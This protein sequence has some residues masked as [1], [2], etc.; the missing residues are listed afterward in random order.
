[1]SLQKVTDTSRNKPI[2]RRKSD[3]QKQA[4]DQN[5]EL[6]VDFYTL[7]SKGVTPSSG[8]TAGFAEIPPHAHTPARGHAHDQ[9]EIYFIYQGEGEFHS[10]AENTLVKAGDTIFIPGGIEHHITNTGT[11]TLKLFYVFDTDSFD[12]ISYTHF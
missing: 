9:N 8:L 5:G 2:I 11:T 6:V 1:M 4:W 12:D 3:T 10:H 7:F